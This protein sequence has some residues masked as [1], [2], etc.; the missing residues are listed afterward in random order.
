MKARNKRIADSHFRRHE[1]V[2]GFV[3]IARNEF[4]GTD[5]YKVGYTTK[6]SAQI[7]I[8]TLNQKSKNGGAAALGFLKLIYDK[9][10]LDSY[11]AEQIAHSALK[12]YR[13]T[14]SR[15]FFKAPLHEIVKAVDLAVKAAD[16]VIQKEHDKYQEETRVQAAE[17][18]KAAQ[19]ERENSLLLQQRAREA[20]ERVTQAK[21][22]LQAAE[23]ARQHRPQIKE[24][25][26]KPKAVASMGEIDI[27]CPQC[28]LSLTA[29]IRLSARETQRIRCP[30]CASIFCTNGKLI[31]VEPA[32]K[33]S[34]PP[35]W[36][37]HFE[38]VAQE[39]KAIKNKPTIIASDIAIVTFLIILIIIFLLGYN[40][41]PPLVTDS[42]I[43]RPAVTSNILVPAQTELARQTL[44]VEFAQALVDYPYL[45]TSSGDKAANLI[46]VEQK[47]LMARGASPSAAFRQ[48]VEIIAPQYVPK[49]LALKETPSFQSTA[50]QEH[51]RLIYDAHPDADS[52][53]ESDSFKSW[54]SM[55]PT[56]QK[57]LKQ[58]T[59]LE[60]IGMLDLYKQA[61]K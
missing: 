52:I 55:A 36:S 56:Y 54:I 49:K 13:V 11:G 33:P 7:R 2:P 23:E 30:K 57:Y 1:G 21:R 60:I 38:G 16:A 29:N 42:F 32:T 45:R 50:D 59:A 40:Q 22:A 61:K 20:A 35:T 48:A 27:S 17:V 15:E 41:T 28:G 39:Q 34:S 9:K 37:P 19:A 18:Q 47:K 26:Y 44:E 12:I 10:T 46:V 24:V 31:K 43:Q 6:E 8:S 58:G 25:P 5:L 53:V 14:D 3:Y 4:H 51:Y